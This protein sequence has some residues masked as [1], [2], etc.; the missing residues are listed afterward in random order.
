MRFEG[1]VQ[2]IFY[3][4]TLPGCTWPTILSEPSELTAPSFVLID[5]AL[6][7]VRRT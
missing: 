3:V 1:I 7:D 5:E 4:Q 2:E 6:K